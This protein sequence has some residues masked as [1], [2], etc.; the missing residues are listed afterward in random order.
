LKQN[1][2]DMRSITPTEELRLGNHLA[3]LKNFS[4]D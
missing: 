3:A 1:G 2:G 4:D